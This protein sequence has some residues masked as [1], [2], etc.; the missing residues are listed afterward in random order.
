MVSLPVIGPATPGAGACPAPIVDRSR[1]YPSCPWLEHGLSF[2]RRSLN[3]CLIV[4]HGRGFPLLADYNGGEVDLAAVQRARARIIA[5]NQQG[6]HEACRGCPH[7]VTRRWREPKRPIGLVAI[8]HFSHC[9][10]ACSYCFLQT[11]DPSVYAAGF[12]PYAVLPVLESLAREDALAARMTVDW[13]GGEPT[14]YREFDQVLSFTALR[15]GITWIHTNGTR[16]PRPIR[17]GL[18]TK[19]IHILCSVD[20]GTR[21]TWKAIKQKDLLDT[22]WRN[23]GDYVRRGCRVVVKYIVKPENCSAE[24]LATFIRRMVASGAGELMIDIDYDAPVPNARVAEGLQ[25]L[26]TLGVRAGLYVTFGATGAMYTPEVEVAGLVRTK[27]S[28]LGRREKFGTN[29]RRAYARL[30]LSHLRRR[31]RYR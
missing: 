24:E 5:E 7:L 19:R 29:R 9:N 23:L 18:P 25:R 16:M 30:L 4:H 2:N 22:V 31:L 15:G 8:A 1:P 11:A 6:G 3:V 28:G 14:L 20:A 27:A 13:G 12:T 10:I 26:W 17:T 21:G